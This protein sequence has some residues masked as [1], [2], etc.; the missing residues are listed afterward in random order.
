MAMLLTE[1]ERK[2]VREMMEN[3]EG[4]NQKFKSGH[5]MVKRSPKE[6]MLNV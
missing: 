6:D 1:V 4:R 5:V 3:G 2:V